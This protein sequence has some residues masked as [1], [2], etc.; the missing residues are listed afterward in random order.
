[1]LL[2]NE[3]YM[4]FAPPA[5]RFHACALAPNALSIG[6]LTKAYGLGA[7]RVGW[8]VLGE[9][10]VPE[11][12]HLLDMSYLAWVDLPTSTL[13]AGLAALERQEEL[14]APLR[15]L[16][17]ESRPVLERWLA[18]SSVVE[19]ELGPYGLCAFPRV[20]GVPD[21]HD[22]QRFLASEHGVDVVA[23]EFFGRPGH[24]RVSYCA[25]PQT[26][27]DGLARLERGIAAF[28]DGR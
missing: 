26:L 20:S 27:S 7:L 21:T 23:G 5:E 8:I 12:E 11:R 28:R 1:V 19:G 6:S 16:E 10:L 3:I 2:S 15:R 13:R 17:R 14:L 22:L 9:G 25:A 18:S 4:E 24:V